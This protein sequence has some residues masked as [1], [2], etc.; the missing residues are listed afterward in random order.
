MKDIRAAQLIKLALQLEAAAGELYKD[1][2][3]TFHANCV[4]DAASLVDYAAHY[5]RRVK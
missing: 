3:L 5:L 4:R 2:A 1:E